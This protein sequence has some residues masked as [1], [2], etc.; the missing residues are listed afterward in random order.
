MSLRLA[1]AAENLRRKVYAS[2]PWGYRL[3]NLLVKLSSIQHDLGGVLYGYFYLAGV[4]GMP[5]PAKPIKEVRDIQKVYRTYGGSEARDF[6]NK[7]YKALLAKFRN[8]DLAEEVVMELLLKMFDPQ[9]NASFLAGLKGKNLSQAQGY[10][11]RSMQ[12]RALDILRSQDR[13]VSM[14]ET[15]DEGKNVERVIAD[16]NQWGYLDDVM[17]EERLDEV[18]E[19]LSKALSVS[20]IDDLLSQ[21]DA[22]RPDAPKIELTVKN[23]REVSIKVNGKSYPLA[24]RTLQDPA[25]SKI[26]KKVPSGKTVDLSRSRKTGVLALLHPLLDAL[27]SEPS[28]LIIELSQATEFFEDLSDEAGGKREIPADI[29]KQMV[30]DLP[31]YFDML[32][33]NKS[34]GEI[35]HNKELPFLAMLEKHREQKGEGPILQPFWQKVFKN[36]VK[37]ALEEVY[38]HRLKHA[39][40]TLTAR[41]R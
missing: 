13:D 21:V 12:N 34:D 17:S 38:S 16:P 30:K 10:T 28:S 40:W 3:A 33:D 4:E 41:C 20:E 29:R 26:L 11:L 31:L 24:F 2:L 27:T 8:P 9:E 22:S 23:P 7:V 39:G 32:L 25:L 37:D 5:E 19:N 36:K 6:G 35:L 15:D 1:A 18:R 14:T